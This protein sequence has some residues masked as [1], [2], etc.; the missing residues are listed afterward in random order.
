[1]Y[2]VEYIFYKLSFEILMVSKNKTTFLISFTFLLKVNFSPFVDARKLEQSQ[3]DT[4]SARQK[5]ADDV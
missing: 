3:I 2:V 1:M 4:A 5:L